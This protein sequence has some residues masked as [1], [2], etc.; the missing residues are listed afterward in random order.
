VKKQETCGPNSLITELKTQ[1]E[2]RTRELGET[3]KALAE[4][5]EQQTAT[6]EV[7]QV[8]SSS[9]GTLDP[10]FQTILQNAVGI[11][12]AKLGTLFLREDDAFRAVAT[13]N[14]P[15]AYELG[16][17]PTATGGAWSEIQSLTSV[18]GSQHQWRGRCHH[19]V[20]SREPWKTPSLKAT[21]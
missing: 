20:A 8:I 15:P 1:L 4:A 2:A 19:P 3:R 10:V 21:R 7:L 11:C 17:A 13:H 5:L 9:P 12:A 18:K 6:S 16:I 14:A